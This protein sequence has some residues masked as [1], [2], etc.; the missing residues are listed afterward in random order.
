VDLME[1]RDSGRSLS[2]KSLSAVSCLRNFACDFT[3]NEQS[4]W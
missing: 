2:Q 3:A 4:R 1:A